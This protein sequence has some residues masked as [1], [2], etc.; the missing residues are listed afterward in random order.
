M[1]GLIVVFV[2]ITGEYDMQSSMIG[3]K[4]IRSYTLDLYTLTLLSI[5]AGYEEDITKS[6]SPTSALLAA[7]LHEYV[8]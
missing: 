1:L 3:K 8:A 2:R 7:Q 5:L 4:L 6:V